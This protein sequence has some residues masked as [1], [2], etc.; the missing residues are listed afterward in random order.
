[1]LLPVPFLQQTRVQ[2]GRARAES[3]AGFCKVR[4]GNCHR[5]SPVSHR[6]GHGA[7]CDR[8]VRCHDG[9]REQLRVLLLPAVRLHEITRIYNVSKEASE[10]DGEDGQPLDISRTETFSRKGIH[11]LIL[12]AA[13][14]CSCRLSCSDPVLFF[15]RRRAR[16]RCEGFRDPN[17]GAWDEWRQAISIQSGKTIPLTARR[18]RRHACACFPMIWSWFDH[19]ALTSPVLWTRTPRTKLTGL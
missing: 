9:R 2:D 10:E 7:A 5:D 3:G 15:L 18:H 6:S 8:N 13:D 11:L 19:S 16:E 14:P 17:R 4:R 12:A 1:M